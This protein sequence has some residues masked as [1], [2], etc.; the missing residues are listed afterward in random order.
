MLNAA[1]SR[2]MAPEAL[3]FEVLPRPQQDADER[4]LR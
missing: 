2:S 1:A 3:A 4:G